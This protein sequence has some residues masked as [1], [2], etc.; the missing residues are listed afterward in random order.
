[1]GVD[2][3]DVGRLQA[4]VADRFTHHAVGAFAVGDGAADVV[5]VAAHAVAHD[6]GQDRR[7][8]AFGAF[9]FFE[10][11]NARAFADNESVAVAGP[12]G[13]RRAA[14]RRCASTARAWRRI[15]RRSRP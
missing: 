13:G 14:D 1:V 6:L 7:T 4:G 10:N 12:R 9:Q 15:R 8:A 3:I 5:S 11:E 2:V